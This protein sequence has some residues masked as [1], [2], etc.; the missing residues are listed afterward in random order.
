[1]LVKYL[2]L[3]SAILIACGGGNNS[4]EIAGQSDTYL[5][6]MWQR[7]QKGS[8][9]NWLRI[10][11]GVEQINL[12]FLFNSYGS[13]N[14]CL[15]KLFNTDKEIRLRS[16]LSNGV[17]IRKNNCSEREIQSIP[18]IELA[19]VAVEALAS[20]CATC[21]LEIVPQLEDNWTHSK[22]CEVYNRLKAITKNDVIRNPVKQSQVD[23]NNTCFDGIELHNELPEG[24]QLYSGSNDGAALLLSEYDYSGLS[25]SV[26]EASRR[27]DALGRDSYYYIW[28]PLGNCL[29]GDTAQAPFPHQR[30]CRDDSQIYTDLNKLLIEGL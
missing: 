29:H 3:L 22:A 24:R 4:G 7:A 8:N 28:H 15:L 21:V 26:A 2:I 16:Y 5:G 11:D 14:T 1:M 23:F 25:I 27:R 17:C 18:D 10:F 20:D 6:I 13:D 19:L 9:C 30:D 12:S